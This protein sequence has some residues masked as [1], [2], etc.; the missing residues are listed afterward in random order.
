MKR[1]FYLSD[2]DRQKDI[3]LRWY[4]R[5]Q[6]NYIDLY[7]NLFISYNAWFK[8]ATSKSRDRDAINELKKRFIIWDEY[9]SGTKM[10]NL[11]PIAKKVSELTTVQPLTNLTGS[12][13]YWDGVVKDE[14][15]WKSLIEYWYR[16]RCNLFHGSKSPDDYR[17]QELIKLAYE[18]LNIF[19]T[20]IVGRMETHM[21]TGTKQYRQTLNRYEELLAEKLDALDT[22]SKEWKETLDEQQDV[23][24]E[25]S[26]L[27]WAERES[28]GLW[29]GDME[30]SGGR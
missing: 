12:D 13:R 14:W 29:S 16:V 22:N 21:S 8:K 7:V 27:E 23:L 5:A 20:E 18:S 2:E 24:S 28:Y 25:Y 1:N 11:V 15:D 9:A 10:N 17:D 26:Q 19:M 4:D 3:V 6:L 30:R